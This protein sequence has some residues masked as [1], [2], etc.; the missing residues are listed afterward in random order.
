METFDI[1]HRAKLLLP[2]L[3][4]QGEAAAWVLHNFGS[5]PAY[6][7][8]LGA[9]EELGDLAHAN[10][11]WEQGIREGAEP[12]ACEMK[13]QDAVGDVVLFLMDYCSANRWD[14]GEVLLD[15][16]DR[17]RVR[18]FKKEPATGGV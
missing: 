14:F 15:T 6:Q 17:V 13:A 1:D 11:K 16:W 10:L 4:L 2:L 3:I 5:R 9:V 12:G 7:P 8:L 18:D